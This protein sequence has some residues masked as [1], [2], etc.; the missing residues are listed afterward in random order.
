MAN[1]PNT[2][3]DYMMILDDG[4]VSPGPLGLVICDASGDPMAEGI[5]QSQEPRTSFKTSEGDLD[6]SDFDPLFRPI[7][8][9]DW[10]GGRGMLDFEDDAARY[11]DGQNIQADIGGQIILGGIPHYTEG[12]WRW[13][14]NRLPGATDYIYRS[15]SLAWYDLVGEKWMARKF[16]AQGAAGVLDS[17]EVWMRRE[18]NGNTWPK[19]YIV[20]DVAGHPGSITGTDKMASCEWPF[21]IGWL[22]Y[23]LSTLVRQQLTIYYPLVNGTTYWFLVKAINGTTDNHWQIGYDNTSRWSVVGLETK[24]SPDGTTWTDYDAG[25]LYFRLTDADN[26]FVAYFAEYKNQLYMAT[27]RDSPTPTNMH[28]YMNGWRGL[29]DDNSGDLSQLID[30]AHGNW[31]DRD[32]SYGIARI[33]GGEGSQEYQPWREIRDAVSPTIL[34]FGDSWKIPHVPSGE[35]ASEYVILGT[36]QWQQIYLLPFPVTDMIQAR[37]R[38]YIAQGEAKV[39][40]TQHA[41]IKWREYSTLA[42]WAGEQGEEANVQGEFLLAHGD[43]RQGPTL[44]VARNFPPNGQPHVAT[45]QVPPEFGDQLITAKPYISKTVAGF[46]KEQVIASVTVTPQAGGQSLVAVAGGFGTGIIC[47]DQ[48]DAEDWRRY[49]KLKIAIRSDLAI[50]GGLLQLLIDDTALC[51]SPF[52]TLDFPTLAKDIGYGPGTPYECEIDLTSLFAADA[53]KTV[54]SV[55]ISLTTDIAA[56]NL[57]VRFL[58]LVPKKDVISINGGKITGLELYGEPEAPWVMTETR[59]YEIRGDYAQPIP[60]REMDSVR[61]TDNGRAHCVQDTYLFFSMGPNFEKYYRGALENLG[62]NLDAGLPWWRKGNIVDAVSAPGRIY[63]AIDGGNAWFSSI[64]LKRGRA[65][66]EVFRAPFA[67]QRIR[68]LHIQTIPGRQPDRLWFSM[69]SDV[70]WIPLPSDMG[71]AYYDEFY[72]YCHEG[73]VTSS[74][75][76]MRLKDI[77]KLFRTFKLISEN[78]STTDENSVGPW[79]RFEYQLESG[80]DYNSGTDWIRLGTN[81]TLSPMQELEISATKAAV[82]RNFR[83]RMI[84]CTDS[85]LQTPRIKGLALETVGRIKPKAV[86][87]F[88]FRV[89]DKALDRSGAYALYADFESFQAKVI[90]LGTDLVVVKCLCPGYKPLHNKYAMFE[91]GDLRPTIV[92]TKQGEMAA[93][94]HGSLI[95]V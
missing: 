20:K 87:N 72:P 60:L 17:M 31:N 22:D 55:G 42:D 58:G 37:D 73:V 40:D 12:P 76:H 59:P 77:K 4:T 10:S 68:R 53:A 89:E 34:A 32:V 83:Y 71:N 45:A 46:M 24:T 41:L 64:L 82:C 39:G 63:I 15:G 84:L 50:S 23:S 48:V 43:P 36:N 54:R 52:A 14:Y 8:Q 38:L 26:P 18:G 86:H 92:K 94:W 62:P 29:A 47:T 33:V 35:D 78:L 61:S 65:Y 74:W 30:A 66:H 67:G 56:F 3:P 51:A 28:L 79:V 93:V 88:F 16:V 95:E 2:V 90:Q 6:Y 27:R 49:E 13:Q 11:Y 80:P 70:C 81:A 21:G 69:G 91:L 85:K 7:L 9:K 25:Q 57:T 44:Y 75:H 5:V 1:F 19:F